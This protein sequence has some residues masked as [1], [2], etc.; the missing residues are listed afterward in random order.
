MG[1]T[2]QLVVGVWVGGEERYIHFNSMAYGQG[3]KSALP[4]YGKFMNKVYSNP[5]L[6]YSQEAKFDFPDGYR[7]SYGGNHHSSGGGG[8]GGGGEA[9]EG[10]FD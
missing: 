1:F 10:I 4:V 5:T 3:A 8:G 7:I 2:P 6:G 9:V